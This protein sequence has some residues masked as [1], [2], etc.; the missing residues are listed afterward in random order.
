MILPTQFLTIHSFI[1]N[2]MGLSTVLNRYIG[3]GYSLQI[4]VY[5]SNFDFPKRDSLPLIASQRKKV[6]HY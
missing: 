5:T 1:Q 2:P 3:K 4:I 6:S